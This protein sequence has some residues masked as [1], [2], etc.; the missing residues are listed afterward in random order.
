[1]VP[2]Y[3]LN[4]EILELE[5]NSANLL[6]WHLS[7]TGLDEQYLLARQKHGVCEKSLLKDISDFGPA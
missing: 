3:S 7:F 4:T 1:M 2:S 6:S 5:L